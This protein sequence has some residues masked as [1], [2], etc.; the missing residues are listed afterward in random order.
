MSTTRSA[1]FAA[2]AIMDGRDCAS[3]NDAMIVTLQWWCM[4]TNCNHLIYL[5]PAV[6]SEGLSDTTIRPS[7][8]LSVPR[9]SC[10]RRAAAVGYRHAGCLCGLRTRPRT[11][12]DPPRVELPSAAG[13]GGISSR[14]P[15]G[16]NLY[17]YKSD[18][19]CI[20]VSVSPFPSLRPQFPADLN[21]R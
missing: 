18:S 15:R 1:R 13:G 21:R 11:D 2:V 8:C 12:V 6:G 10:R 9:R 19:V 14:R 5:C 7:V 4:L 16:D 17:N 20:H 3:I